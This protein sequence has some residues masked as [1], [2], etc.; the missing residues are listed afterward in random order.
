M[1]DNIDFKGLWAQQ[2][3]GLPNEEELFLRLD[4][5]KKANLKRLVFTNLVL[6]ATSIFI[7]FIWY[8]Y[9]PQFIST[10]I[11]IVLTI[12]AMVM[13]L[14]VYNQL[15]PSFTKTAGDQSNQEYL[16]TLIRIRTKQEFLQTKMLHV[17]FIML[18]VGICLYMIEYA[19]R[20]SIL[21]AIVT[22]ALTLFWMG[23]NWFYI[24]PRTVKK[25]QAKLNE[26]ISKM[27]MLTQQLNRNE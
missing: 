9:Q 14:F 23:F 6:I 10:K 20:L 2:P 1:E 26:L 27:E 24:H 18:S 4:R 15:L 12:L 22:Y 19:S 8:Q 11:G 3:V 21:W 17:Y 13:Y 5:H 16:Q 25:Q 7:G